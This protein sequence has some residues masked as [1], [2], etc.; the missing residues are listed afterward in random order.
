MLSCIWDGAYKRT[1]VANRNNVLSA[2]LNKTFLSCSVM[3]LACK[4]VSPRR[5]QSV[6]AKIGKKT[7]LHEI[8]KMLFK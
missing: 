7:T 2:S 8:L 4:V 5:S 6:L 3:L 1:I